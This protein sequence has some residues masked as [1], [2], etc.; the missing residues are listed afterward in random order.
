MPEPSV[1][2]SESLL[3]TWTA[4]V[5]FELFILEGVHTLCRSRCMNMY[6]CVASVWVLHQIWCV[7]VCV[8]VCVCVNECTLYMPGC[9]YIYYIQYIHTC[10]CAFA[11]VCVCVCNRIHQNPWS[12]NWW[13]TS[14]LKKSRLKRNKHTHEYNPNISNLCP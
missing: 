6:K 10:W 5:C 3:V 2:R 8:C 4:R 12:H 11:H 7:Y 1:T 13:S 9:V 14:D